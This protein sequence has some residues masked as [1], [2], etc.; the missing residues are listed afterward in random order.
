MAV[1]IYIN[2]ITKDSAAG[3]EYVTG[4][5]PLVKII[6]WR[7]RY[8]MDKSGTFS[9]SCVAT[10]KNLS[11]IKRLRKARCYAFLGGQYVEIGSGIITDIQTGFSNGNAT[12]EV[13]GNDMLYELTYRTVKNLELTDTLFGIGHAAALSAISAYAP[14]GWTFTPS[15]AP[16]SDF[17]YHKYTGDTVLAALNYLVEATQTHFVVTGFRSLEYKSSPTAT[18]IIATD[19]IDGEG[20]GSCGIVD[21]KVQE[22]S[23]DFITRI[24]PYGAGNDTTRF[25]LSAT[26]RSAP[27][28]YELNTANNFIRHV[29]YETDYDRI[30]REIQ[31]SQ[32]T[33]RIANRLINS[34]TAANMLFDLALYELKQRVTAFEN[35]I[36]SAKL[37]GCNVAIKP[38]D[39]IRVYYNDVNS[40]ILINQDMWVT[41][42][43]VTVDANG[44]ATTGVTFSGQPY[45]VR[46][47]SE[48]FLD[49]VYRVL[50]IQ[51][52]QQPT[53]ESY[54]VP[55]SG[56]ITDGTGYT[57]TMQFPTNLDQTYSV[58]IYFT[59]LDGPFTVAN[60]DLIS[61]WNSDAFSGLAH[62]TSATNIGNGWYSYNLV[63]AGWRDF[64]TSQTLDLSFDRGIFDT[65]TGT[66]NIDAFV[67]V[68]ANR[69]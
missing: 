34:V 27:A 13:S 57:I 65:T 3:S 10:S 18:G 51:G 64:S 44:I 23:G 42:S 67:R 55:F 17:V 37:V 56:S 32:V 39:S 46:T 62:M 35:P 68:S 22:T 2:I 14:S 41:A 16:G 9:F 24:Y 7:N 63:S 8:E 29:G 15:G 21:L 38:L 28:G 20:A 11:L 49:N 69:G 45:E 52:V 66:S 4:D 61:H 36:Y 59:I 60:I 33:P 53:T 31:Y 54:S 30:E 1:E 5:A 12:L 47:A 19:R 6:K 40:G 50:R 25:T 58:T 48:A 43:E 26:T